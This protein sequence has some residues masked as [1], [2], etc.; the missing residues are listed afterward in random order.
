MKPGLST[1]HYALS[2]DHSTLQSITF[3][4]VMIISDGCGSGGGKEMEWSPLKQECIISLQ[5]LLHFLWIVRDVIT[6]IITPYISTDRARDSLAE[7]V[8]RGR[9][10]SPMALASKLNPF[11]YG[12]AS[13]GSR[14]AALLRQSSLRQSKTAASE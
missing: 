8:V 3:L 6:E 4:G 1:K 7:Y 2:L 12:G 10:K 5:L 9:E 11:I 14:A 13:N